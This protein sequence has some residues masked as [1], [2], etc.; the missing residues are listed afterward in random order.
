MPRMA[1][2]GVSKSKTG[3]VKS[4]NAFVNTRRLS[5]VRSADIAARIMLGVS[6][7]TTST[8]MKR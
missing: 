8:P 5:P 2:T 6:T 7:L 1:T 3:V 4:S